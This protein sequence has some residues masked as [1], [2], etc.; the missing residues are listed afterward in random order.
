MLL[1][2]EEPNEEAVVHPYWYARVIEIFHVDIIHYGPR[3]TSPEKQQIDVLWVRWFGGDVSFN[4]GWKAKRLHRIGFLDASSP[5]AFGFL[6]PAEV[7]CSAHIVP[8]FAHEAD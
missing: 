2:H 5:G 6:N 4:A 3:S 7:I 1:S 8:A